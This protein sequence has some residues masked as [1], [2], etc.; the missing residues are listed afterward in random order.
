MHLTRDLGI[1]AEVVEALAECGL[2]VEVYPDT[3]VNVLNK[4]HGVL[5]DMLKDAVIEAYGS[6][7]AWVDCLRDAIKRLN[8]LKATARAFQRRQYVLGI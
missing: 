5:K 8:G 7:D 6:W 3:P 2:P 1:D 4:V